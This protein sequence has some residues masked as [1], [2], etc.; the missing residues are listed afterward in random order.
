MNN[1][2][3]MSLIT[4]TEKDA[5]YSTPGNADRKPDYFLNFINKAQFKHFVLAKCTFK[6][7]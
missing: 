1:L 7:K 6:N 5:R 3:I 4:I 2:S